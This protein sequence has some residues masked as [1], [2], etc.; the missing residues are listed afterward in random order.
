ML[1]QNR[2]Q[3]L[4]PRYLMPLN[5]LSVVTD[6]LFQVLSYL[7]PRENPHMAKYVYFFIK[8]LHV[9]FILASQVAQW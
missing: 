7:S 2:V 6:N 8:F 5:K 1:S 4:L 9:T 3:I